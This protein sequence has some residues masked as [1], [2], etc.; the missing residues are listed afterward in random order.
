MARKGRKRHWKGTTPGVREKRERP[1]EDPRVVVLFQPHR[2]GSASDRLWCPVGRLLEMEGG[3]ATGLSKS[4]LYE[5]SQRFAEAYRAWQ[6]VKGSKRPLANSASGSDALE[7]CVYPG[8]DIPCE[9]KG[10]C[11]AMK[12]PKAWSDVWRELRGAGE[13]AEKAVFFTVIDPQPEDWHPPFWVQ[14]AC[15]HGL[16]AIAK[17]YGIEWDGEDKGKSS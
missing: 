10:E 3:H 1:P 4:G 5:A 9:C 7:R 17:H 11:P 6:S 8:P 13:A 14:N 16:I 12:W 2:R 15:V